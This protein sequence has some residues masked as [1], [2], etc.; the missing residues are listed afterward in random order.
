MIDISACARRRTSLR[1]LLSTTALLTGCSASEPAVPAIIGSESE[2]ESRWVPTDAPKGVTYLRIGT[3][4]APTELKYATVDGLAVFQGDIILGAVSEL[5][6]SPAEVTAQGVAIT[7]AG[8]RWPGALV[9]FTI[10]AGLTNQARVTTAIR[11][12]QE[13]T[14]VRFILRDASNAALFPDFVTFQPHATACNSPVGKRGG[15]QF[16]NLTVG[17]TT[18]NAIHEIGHALGFWHEHSREDRNSFVTINLSN[19]RV[20]LEYAFDQH[21]ADGDDV[22][23]YDYGSI[24][25]YGTHDFSRNDLPTITVLTPGAIIGQ[26][27][28]LSDGDIAATH[29]MYPVP[30]YPMGNRFFTMDYDGDGDDD[31]VIRGPGGEF[32]AYVANAGTFT[33]ALGDLMTTALSDRHGWNEEHRFFVADYDGDGDDDLVI[34]NAAGEFSALRSERTHF[35]NAGPLLTG[36]TYSDANGWGTGN[37]FWVMDY[38][39]DG[40]DDLVARHPSGEFVG[41]RSNGTTLTSVPALATTMLSDANNWNSGLRFFVADY[42]GDGK[43]DLITRNGGGDFNALR[44]NGTQL[45][46]MP[47]LYGSTTF[48]DANGWGLG[49]RIF[50]ADYDGDGDDDLVLRF[51]GGGLGALNANAGALSLVTLLSSSYLTDADAWNDANRFFVADVDGDGDDDLIARDADGA[52]HLVRSSASG[53]TLPGIVANTTFRDP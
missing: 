3:N 34:R 20:G 39:E 45:V 38:D 16:I 17:C 11:H 24:M 9:P 35:V 10:D 27:I 43:D 13:R 22:G 29:Q 47:L 33:R 36:T 14:N 6:K 12:W 30:A 4:S 32:F 37:R 2:A 23:A 18:G 53:L 46:W 5:P 21:I 41:L 49:N 48:S 15:Q 40:D 19:V 7:G 31:L 42:D 8:Y 50:A 1:L 51:A 52:F 25:H 26:R 44:S 28:G